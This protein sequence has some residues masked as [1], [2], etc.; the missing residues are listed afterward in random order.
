MK[1]II[2]RAS[3][4]K[5]YVKIV[6]RNGEKIWKTGDGYER[7][8]GAYKALKLLTSEMTIEEK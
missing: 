3:N 7:K 5:W 4:K 8:A 6:G 1:A 2:Y